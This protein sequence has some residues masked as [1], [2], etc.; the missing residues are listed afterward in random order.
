MSFVGKL[1][2]QLQGGVESFF[3]SWSHRRQRVKWERQ[4]ADPEYNP[5]WKTEKPQKELIDAIHSGWFLK[6]QL[7]IDVGCGKGEVSR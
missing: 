1:A 3:P 6:G 5:F 4:W 7:V 2:N